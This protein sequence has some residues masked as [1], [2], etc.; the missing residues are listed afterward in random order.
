MHMCTTET[1]S[2]C[3]LPFDFTTN[4]KKKKKFARS[5]AKHQTSWNCGIF[6]PYCMQRSAT[7]PIVEFRLHSCSFAVT[8][9]THAIRL[10]STRHTKGKTPFALPYF[11]GPKYVY[12]RHTR[13]EHRTGT[14][15]CMQNSALLWLEKC[16]Q[17]VSPSVEVHRTCPFCP[18][19]Q[20]YYATKFDP[21]KILATEMLLLHIQQKMTTENYMP[22]N[23]NN[24]IL[25][26]LMR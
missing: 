11:V 26:I 18:S 9:R 2:N 6:G 17:F 15:I 25:S 22:V 7:V 8:E 10:R 5:K 23:I 13:F 21:I 19:F 14:V 1:S 20:F 12:R 16:H 24:N 4:Q 3:V